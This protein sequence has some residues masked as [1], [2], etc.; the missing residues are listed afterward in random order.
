VHPVRRLILAHRRLAALVLAAAL[1]LRLIVPGGYMLAEH[2]GVMILKVCSGV[3]QD[4]AM[5][6][7]MPG[8]DHAGTADHD[9]SKEHGKAEMP[10]AFSGLSAQLLGPVDPALLAIALAAVAM[11]AL[12][13]PAAQPAQAR[14]HLR[15]PTRAPPVPRLI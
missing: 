1:A 10:C 9:G 2:H 13:R 5:V 7:P 15:P 11:A 12:V 8:M 14:V 3:A 6:M 4:R